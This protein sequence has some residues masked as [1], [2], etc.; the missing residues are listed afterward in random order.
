MVHAQQIDILTLWATSST[1]LK[2]LWTW[3]YSYSHKHR[4][5]R[6]LSS[7]LLILTSLTP[8]REVFAWALTQPVSVSLWGMVAYLK[9]QLAGGSDW[10]GKSGHIKPFVGPLTW[11]VTC[12]LDGRKRCSKKEKDRKRDTSYQTT[13]VFC[14]VTQLG[15]GGW[16][17]VADLTWYDARKTH[18]GVDCTKAL[19]YFPSTLYL[20]SSHMHTHGPIHCC[21]PCS[22][23]LICPTMLPPTFFHSLILSCPFSIPLSHFLPHFCSI[24]LPSVGRESVRSSGHGRSSSAAS[25]GPIQT[26]L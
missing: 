9:L 4:E 18:S 12:C 2:G 5:S 7:C 8:T 26:E 13:D 17:P 20:P 23:N 1:Q 6:S 15:G 14:T 11:Q 21:L 19:F 16:S 3:L 22:V 10:G 24:W 25:H